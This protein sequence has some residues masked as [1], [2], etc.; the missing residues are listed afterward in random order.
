MRS[1]DLLTRA[2]QPLGQENAARLENFLGRRLRDEPVS[3]ILGHSG[4]YGLDLIVTPDVLDPRADTEVLVDAALAFLREAPV[5]RPR[6]L[7]LG[8]GSGAILCAIL[9][10]APDAYGLGVDLSLAACAVARKNLDRCG[11]A[12]RSSVL[13]G[14]WAAAM[15]GRFDVIVSN[16]PYIGLDE[17]AALEPEVAQFD[18]EL[19]LFGGQDGLDCHRRLARDIGRLLK[20]GG[21]AFFEIG[22][23]Q[24]QSVNRILFDSGFGHVAISRDH[25]GRDRVVSVLR[26]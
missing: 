26:V 25:G 13:C 23:R 4:F 16:P 15:A 2:D 17:A 21:G 5:A 6:I 22:W 20:P 11:L 1:L 19:A 24:A 3:R 8:T 10:A 9:R 14:D 12:D 18:P 7:D